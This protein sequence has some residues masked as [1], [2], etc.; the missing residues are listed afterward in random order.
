MNV[1]PGTQS[2]VLH[3]RDPDVARN[4]GT[5]DQVHWLVW[6][7]PGTATGLPENVPKGADLADGSR[8]IGAS[9]P[10][11]RPGRAGQRSH[12]PLHFRALR[13][14]HEARR[15]RRSRRL[16]NADGGVESHGRARLE[17][18][19][20]CGALPAATVSLQSSR[21]W[22]QSSYTAGLR[23]LRGAWLAVTAVV[24][25]AATMAM[26]PLSLA[27]T[28]QAS[29]DLAPVKRVVDDYIGLHE[30]AAA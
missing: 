8:Q 11:Y 24:G 27:R 22:V 10:V 6:N 16:G 5:E 15:R 7:I 29:S 2:F 17:Q 21:F 19:G 18:G 4:R 25:L 14:G 28:T 30:G 3:M 20:A 9:G 13:A 12:A 23:R 26:P 1:P